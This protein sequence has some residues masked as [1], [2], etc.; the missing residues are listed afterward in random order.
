VQHPDLDL[1][2]DV[3]LEQRGLEGLHRTGR[4][5]LDDEVEFL[6]QTSLERLVQILQGEPDTL[7][8][9]ADI[10]LGAARFSAI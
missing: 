2:A 3:E 1:F 5:A 7:A 9:E 4:V 6:D 10:A 8:G